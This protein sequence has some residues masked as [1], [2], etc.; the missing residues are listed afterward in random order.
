MFVGDDSIRGGVKNIVGS[1]NRSNESAYPFSG[2]QV[3][4]PT[5]KS[6]LPSFQAGHRSWKHVDSRIPG[7]GEQFQA[8]S[9]DCETTSRAS[10]S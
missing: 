6:R 1:E 10:L 9:E 3:R 2:R 7:L 8:P 4:V 5:D